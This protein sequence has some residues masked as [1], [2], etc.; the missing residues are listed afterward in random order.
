MLTGHAIRALKCSS[1]NAYGVQLFER[2]K[3]RKTFL[4]IVKPHVPLCCFGVCFKPQIQAMIFF[5]FQLFSGKSSF[6]TLFIFL[7]FLFVHYFDDRVGHRCSLYGVLQEIQN[8]TNNH[9][10][11]D[12]MNKHFSIQELEDASLNHHKSLGPDKITNEMLEN[13]GLKAKNP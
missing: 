8:H 2:F 13:L 6:S 5:K 11:P 9:Y 4:I 10:T 12:C 7:M 3:T 1:F